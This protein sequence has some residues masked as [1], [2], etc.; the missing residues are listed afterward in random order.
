VSIRNSQGKTR[1]QIRV[2][3]IYPAIARDPQK[4]REFMEK[5]GVGWVTIN[6]LLDFRED[7][8]PDDAIIESWACQYPF[9]R[10]TISANGIMLPCTGAHNDESGL[11]LGRY[12]GT[13]PKMTRNVDGSFATV[14]VEERTLY[15]AWHGEKLQNIRWLHKNLR[16]TE[17]TPGCRNCR[18]GAIKH[19]VDWVP[20]DWNMDTMEWEGGTWRE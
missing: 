14:E 4:Y 9:Q 17:I 2:N 12:V 13:P 5:I 19:G 11:V 7:E 8:L 3:S 18:H 10:L 15:Q 16:R 1:P 20:E 6:E